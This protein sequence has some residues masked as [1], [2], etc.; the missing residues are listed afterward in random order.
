MI[1]IWRMV[2]WRFAK[3]FYPKLDQNGH[4]IIEEV[5]QKLLYI[6]GKATDCLFHVYALTWKGDTYVGFRFLKKWLELG[7]RGVSRVTNRMQKNFFFHS[8]CHPRNPPYTQYW[9]FLKKNVNPTK[10]DSFHKNAKWIKKL[11]SLSVTILH[12]EVPFG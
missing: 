4:L 5:D 2:N 9:P 11:I 1:K 8:I 3:H 6:L 10:I 12:W 7:V